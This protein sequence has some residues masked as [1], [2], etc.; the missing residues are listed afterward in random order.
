MSFKALILDKGADG[1][2]S[3]KIETIGEDRLPADGNVTVAVEYSTLNYKDGLC[4]TG[5]GGL[6]RT[7]PHVAGVDFAEKEQRDVQVFR[8]NPLDRHVGGAH[9]RICC[10]GAA[11]PDS[12]CSARRDAMPRV[13]PR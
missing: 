7:Y 12:R 9:G 10:A 3:A 11:G 6:V 5:M 13:R 4:L 2:V 1:V 8:L